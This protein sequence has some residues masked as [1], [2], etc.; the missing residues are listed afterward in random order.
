MKCSCSWTP[1]LALAGLAALGLGGYNMARTGCPLG[2]CDS[3]STTAASVS[4]AAHST[5]IAA[6]GADKADCCAVECDKTAADCALCPHAQGDVVK[7]ASFEAAPAGECAAKSECTG[8]T[9]KTACE[10]KVQCPA[11]AK[12]AD[13]GTPQT[14]PQN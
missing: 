12:V 11:A 9:A 7:T 2:T 13:K 6:E 4:P 3:Q 8:Q 5:A 1:L 14:P 10:G